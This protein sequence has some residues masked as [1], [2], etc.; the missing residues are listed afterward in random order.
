M[1][2]EGL[3][4]YVLESCFGSACHTNDNSVVVDNIDYYFVK[5]GFI[6]VNT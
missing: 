2:L 1:G 5:K 3:E 4:I 6:V